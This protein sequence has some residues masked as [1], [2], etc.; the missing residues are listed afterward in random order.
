[1]TNQFRYLFENKQKLYT[2]PMNFIKTGQQINN[3]KIIE[4]YWSQGKPSALTGNFSV[5]SSP[6][7]EMRFSA[8][9]RKKIEKINL[10]QE[11]TPFPKVL[12]LVF[13]NSTDGYLYLN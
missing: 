9:C 6:A 7:I 12:G 8:I 13:S 10:R 11:N 5:A 1:M 2:R 3:K 4:I